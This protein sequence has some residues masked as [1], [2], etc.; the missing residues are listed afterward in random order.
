MEIKDIQTLIQ[1]L[2]ESSVAKLKWVQGD[3]VITLEKERADRP[4]ILTSEAAPMPVPAA[5][6]Q[7]SVQPAVLEAAQPKIAGTFVKAPLVGVFYGASSPEADPF[8]K[9]GQRVQKGETVCILEAM[10]VLNEIK[11]PASGILQEI[12]V[13][14]GQVVEFDQIL[15]E[16]GDADV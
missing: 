2:D 11:A 7:P 9:V 5:A 3:Q 14:N 12:L 16:I 8:V 1:T 15:M 10:K 13:E 4:V 6:I